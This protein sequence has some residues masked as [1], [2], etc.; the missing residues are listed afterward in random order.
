MPWG[1]FSES[2]FVGRMINSQL[3]EATIWFPVATTRL[4]LQ[5]SLVNN[6]EYCCQSTVHHRSVCRW[7]LLFWLIWSFKKVILSHI[8]NINSPT[9]L[10]HSVYLLI[11]KRFIIVWLVFLFDQWICSKNYLR[12]RRFNIFFWASQLLLEKLLTLISEVSRK[13]LLLSFILEFQFSRVIQY[14]VSCRASWAS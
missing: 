14:F 10:C 1:I 13:A 7:V 8:S 9:N 5:P 4:W 6:K 3:Q 12:K 2:V 11:W